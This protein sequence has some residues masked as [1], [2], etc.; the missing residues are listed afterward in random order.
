[1]QS[2]KIM[3]MSEP[4]ARCTAM[5]SSGPRNTGLPSTGERKATPCLADLA[6]LAEAEDLETAGIREDRAA[7]SA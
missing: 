1:V 2:S 4:S 7:A 3:T 6:Q 5:D